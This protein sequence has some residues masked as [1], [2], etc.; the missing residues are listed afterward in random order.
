MGDLP[1]THS[2]LGAI[3]LHLSAVSTL[4]VPSVRPSEALKSPHST[5][6]KGPSRLTVF[7]S[8]VRIYTRV[9]F[10]RPPGLVPE[11]FRQDR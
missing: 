7:A 9:G 11:I 10:L 3:R 8:I 5:H 6:A 2:R 1:L 4:T